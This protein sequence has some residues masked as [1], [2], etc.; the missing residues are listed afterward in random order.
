MRHQRSE[1][2]AGTAQLDTAVLNALAP[3][4]FRTILASTLRRRLHH[5]DGRALEPS[6]LW[7]DDNGLAAA[8]QVRASTARSMANSIPT[9]R[10]PAVEP[11]VN[12]HMVV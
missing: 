12:Q 4:S 5:A 8:D 2:P 10:C 7:V 1:G 11:F 3:I 9:K 6:A